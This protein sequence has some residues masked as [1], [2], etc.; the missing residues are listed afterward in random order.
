M[1]SKKPREGGSN[2]MLMFSGLEAQ[3]AL[4]RLLDELCG[5]RRVSRQE[6]GRLRGEERRSPRGALAEPDHRHLKLVVVS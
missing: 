1:R 3:G 2:E 4:N 6:A 5:E